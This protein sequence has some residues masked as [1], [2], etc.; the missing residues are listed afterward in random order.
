MDYGCSMDFASRESYTDPNGVECMAFLRREGR[1]ARA[2]TPNL[3]RLELNMR[4]K[5]QR[6]ASKNGTRAGAEAR[7]IPS[8]Y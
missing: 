1:Y 5:G 3:L 7:A 8:P 4:F 2:L 6:A